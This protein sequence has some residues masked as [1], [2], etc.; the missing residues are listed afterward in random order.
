MNQLFEQLQPYLDKSIAYDAALTLLNWD[1]ETLA[2]KTAISNTSKI[3]GLL[4]MESYHTLVNPEVKDLITRLSVEQEQKNLTEIQRVI[5]RKIKKDSDTMDKI[6]AKEYQDYS[7]LVASSSSIWAKAKESNRFEDFAKTLEKLINYEKKFA[8]Y[9]KKE[10]ETIYDYLLDKYEEGMNTAK[11]DIFFDK[12]R[13]V[14]VPLLKK[15]V[16]KNKV[17]DK[18]YNSKSYDIET[19]KKFCRFLA[20]YIGFDF[21]RGVMAES[22]HPFTTHL[23]NKDVRITNHYIENNLESAIFSVIH[24]GGHAIYEMQI[25]DDISLTPVGTGTS[26]GFHESQ[27]RLFENHF[28]RN[29]MFWIPLFDKLK[30]TYKEQL[31]ELSLDDFIL[32]I[33]KVEPSFIRTEADELTYPLHIMIRYELEKQIFSGELK[34]DEL[35][36]AWDKKYEEY[37]GITPPTRTLGILQDVH[38]SCGMFGYF[39]SY[40]LGSAISAQIYSDMEKKFPIETYLKESNLAPIHDYLKENFHKYGATK[41]TNELLI[42]ATNEDLNV[43]YYITY[44]TKKYTELYNLDENLK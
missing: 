1:I 8:Q 36:D 5:V 10:N 31:N 42:A 30:E 23:H 33:N 3:I 25:A 40:A 6:P 28:G 35:A 20:E 17:I 21:N 29:K 16:E 2:P 39:P 4:S 24:E 37:L 12:I 41:T 26:M 22:A 32:A 15:I 18:S 27:S 9:C 13:S 38:W 34:I 19:Q 11:L 7:E 44:L 14:I 43:D